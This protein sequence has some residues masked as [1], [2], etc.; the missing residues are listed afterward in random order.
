MLYK[1]LF[2]TLLLT[3]CGSGGSD[4]SSP[5]AAQEVTPVVDPPTEDDP[6]G[7]AFTAF[8][9]ALYAAAQG[10]TWGGLPA[11][12]LTKLLVTDH[13]EN[14]SRTVVGGDKSVTIT[15]CDGTTTIKSYTKDDL[16][17]VTLY[18]ECNDM[19]YNQRSRLKL[20][21]K[22]FD[23]LDEQAALFAK[24]IIKNN[25]VHIYK[26]LPNTEQITFDYTEFYDI[27]PDGRIYRISRGIS[28]TDV[29]VD[30]TL[31]P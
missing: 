20:G 2:F 14:Y 26:F 24:N 31:C 28:G 11:D 1:I 13:P 27:C 30:H 3:A 16:S 9:T 18:D 15:F 5:E 25:S 17:V 8:Q 10:Q 23:V 7:E 12:P 4:K 6:V 22:L 29:Q 19:I 21:I